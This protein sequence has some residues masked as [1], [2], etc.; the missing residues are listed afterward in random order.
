MNIALGGRDRMLRN[1]AME[2]LRFAFVGVLTLD[3][4]VDYANR[5]PLDA[6]GMRLPLVEHHRTEEVNWC[7]GSTL[8][9]FHELA[10]DILPQW[11]P[12]V[13]LLPDVLPLEHRLTGSSSERYLPHQWQYLFLHRW[14]FR[15][16][17][18]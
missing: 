17:L 8:N 12:L 3:G 4:K 18:L 15:Y 16:R 2:L 1:H 11:R 10:R 6:A 13:L 7:V 9:E 5:A 14:Q